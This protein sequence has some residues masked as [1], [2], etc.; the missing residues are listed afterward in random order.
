MSI[1]YKA[2][3]LA[4]ANQHV[5][6]K[7]PLPIFSSG[8]G[9]WSIFQREE[10][11]GRQLHHPFVL[12][13][14]PL[15]ED[16]R[17]SYMVTEYVP[18]RTLAEVLTERRTLPEREALAIASQVCAALEH[19]HASGFVHYDLKPANIM[20][21]PDGGIRLIDFGLAHATVTSRFAFSG[22]PPAIGSSGYIAPEQIK[23]KRGR[24]SVDIYGI[25]AVL[26][27]ML[28]GQPPFPG[29]DAFGVG[30]ARL[31][32]DPPS[33]RS[34]NPGL[35]RE[36]EEIVLRALRRDPSERYPSATA[37]KADL[38]HPAEVVVTG[39][40]ERLQ[41]ATRWRRSLRKIRYVVMVCVVPVIAQVVLFALLYRR[42]S[43]K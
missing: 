33:P 32:G 30:S 42:F 10:Q 41:P 13:F 8:V 1:L 18:G 22:A 9:G 26:Y 7:V 40:G 27:E 2:D 12:K 25:G 20:L 29:D 38:D 11:I 15:P 31:V 5:V 36:A 3:D 43:H 39:L 14:L 16:K 4:Q 17:R 34:L 19:V 24:T 23:R 35:S 6:V 37:M 28:T 21:C